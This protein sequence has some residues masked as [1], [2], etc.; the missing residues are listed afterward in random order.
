MKPVAIKFYTSKGNE[1][2][3]KMH[4]SAG[5]WLVGK[6]EGGKEREREREGENDLFQFGYFSVNKKQIKQ[7]ALRRAEFKNIYN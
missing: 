4:V 6:R 2:P 3:P 7:T 5:H 1:Y